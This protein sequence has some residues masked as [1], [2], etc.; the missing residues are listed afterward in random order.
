[1][2]LT[3]VD[4]VNVD[5]K[6]EL[7]YFLIDGKFYGGDQDTI[8]DR[9]L[10][11]AGCAAITA[12]DLCIYSDLYCGTDLYPYDKNHVTEKEYVRFASD[13]MKRCITPGLRGVD[14]LERYLKGFEKYQQKRGVHPY[15]LEAISGEEDLEKAKES[16]KVSIH[17]GIPVVNLTLRHKER[18]TFEDYS[19]HWF[20]FNG[21]EEK[22]SQFLVKTVSYGKAIW[23]NFEQLWDTGY[24]DKGGMILFHP[25]ENFF[26]TR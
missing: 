5:M 24:D 23:L 10:Q 18:K 4:F 15:D 20:I 13:M 25:V 11:F 26:P 1:M 22:E 14:T 12:S 2:S 19:W 8:P 6:K 17:A 21:Y 7:D 9:L 3:S 16:L